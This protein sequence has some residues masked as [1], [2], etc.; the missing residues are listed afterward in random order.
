MQTLEPVHV[1]VDT[2]YHSTRN[3]RSKVNPNQHVVQQGLRM[4]TRAI[5]TDKISKSKPS[6]GLVNRVPKRVITPRVVQPVRSRS[7]SPVRGPWYVSIIDNSRL[8][9]VD[10]HRSY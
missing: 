4:R 8:F 9:Y 6:I 5:T 3:V 10:H 7:A 1:R 2:N